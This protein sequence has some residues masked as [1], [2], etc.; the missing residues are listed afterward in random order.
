MGCDVV[1]LDVWETSGFVRWC[2]YWN[3]EKHIALC[4]SWHEDYV[5]R[6]RYRGRESGRERTRE[7]EKQRQ[8][9]LD[10]GEERFSFS[11]SLFLFRS[12]F[13]SWVGWQWG[14]TQLSSMQCE[15]QYAYYM[16]AERRHSIE[17]DAVWVLYLCPPPLSFVLLCEMKNVCTICPFTILHTYICPWLQRYMHY[18]P[19]FILFICLF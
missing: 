6:E 8:G 19:Q 15:Y 7:G 3:Q 10:S 14:D 16:D 11:V 1:G 12:F 17:F 5:E 9:E 2:S 13:L 18:P 4:C